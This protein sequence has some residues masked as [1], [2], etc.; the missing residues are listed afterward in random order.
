MSHGENWV[1]GDRERLN[2]NPSIKSLEFDH[3]LAA[4]RGRREAHVSLTRI[5]VVMGALVCYAQGWKL[6]IFI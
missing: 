4:T 5:R 3:K 2:L 1:E 6:D